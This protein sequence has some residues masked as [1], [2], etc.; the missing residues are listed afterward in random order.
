M[1]HKPWNTGQRMEQ[2]KEYNTQNTN[3]WHEKREIDILFT[4]MQE[5]G[6]I[7]ILRK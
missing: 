7:G 2:W 6:I 3:A 5:M 1:Q 4:G